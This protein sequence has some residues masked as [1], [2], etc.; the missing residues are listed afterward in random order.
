MHTRARIGIIGSGIA[1]SSA[2]LFLR[3]A[4]GKDMDIVVFERARRIG[5]R[6][7]HIEADGTVMETG[8]LYGVAYGRYMLDFVRDLN[9]HPETLTV[10]ES[11]RAADIQE[12]HQ[13]PPQLGS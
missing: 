2:A 3:R 9:L 13:F 7:S 1:G 10:W 11:S 8:A 5:G 12:V 4:L 6:T